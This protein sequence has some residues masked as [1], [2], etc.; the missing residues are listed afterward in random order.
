MLFP[1][2]T[3][4]VFFM[5]VLPL[6]WLLMPARAMWKVFILLASWFFL[7]YATQ[8]SVFGVIPAFV[9]LLVGSSVWNWFWGGQVYRIDTDA[10]RRWLVAIAVGGNLL[11][12]G[13][14]KYYDFF[15]VNLVNGFAKIGISIP[16]DPVHV[17]LPVAIS[18][19]TF[20]GMSYVIDC[21]RY[22]FS[23]VSLP[24][25]LV[26][27]SFFPHLIAGPIVRAAEFVPQIDERHNPRRI[28]GSRALALITGG[29]FKKLVIADF[30]G[31][32][33]VQQVFPDPHHHS[34]WTLLVAVYAYAVQIYADFSGYTDI[35]IGLAL[36]LG[37]RFPQNFDRPYTATSIQDFWRR[38]HMTL[39]RWL[40]DYLYIPLGGNRRAWIPG[41][42]WVNLSDAGGPGAMQAPPRTG[43]PVRW[44]VYGN[45]MITM[46]L[47]GLWH[48][49]GW[50][51]L[52]WGGLHGTFQVVEHARRRRRT[53]RGI[54][55]PADTVARRVWLRV[56]TFHLVCLGWIF[57]PTRMGDL[58]SPSL[59]DSLY[60]VRH[61]LLPWEWQG[62]PSPLVKTSVLLAIAVGIGVQYVPR[63]VGARLLAQWSR[64]S[65]VAIGI[66]I[67][68]ALLV[69]DVLGVAARNGHVPDFIYFQF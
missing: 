34:S 28:D 54:P 22:D 39:S 40:R 66:S 24:N 31:R 51:F 3:F 13:Y 55:E 21:F 43:L 63:R 50:S 10:T 58:R 41:Q 16:L 48:G 17:V 19:Y 23:P 56:V 29:L 2:V 67:G 4:A 53:A 65:P 60:I 32:V 52:V 11:L 27:Q 20:C 33:I 59:S 57:F 36:L 64:L 61:L 6:S 15:A 14:F 1:T 38:W 49:A 35:A 5:V 26:Y 44:F 68:V 8:P 42:G 45:V 9:L 37:F 62:G 30:L 18:F 25:F 7:A 12:L 47:G 69:I 46:L